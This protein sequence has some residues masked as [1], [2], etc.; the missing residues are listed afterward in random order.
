MEHAPLIN[1]TDFKHYIIRYVYNNAI[2]VLY[3][4]VNKCIHGLIKIWKYMH[5]SFHTMREPFPCVRN[6]KSKNIS[7]FMQRISKNCILKVTFILFILLRLIPPFSL[8]SFL[9]SLG[10]LLF[11]CSLKCCQH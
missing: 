6:G 7:I 8:Y 4:L 11:H 5:C 2:D 9:F 10:L 1:I 3:L